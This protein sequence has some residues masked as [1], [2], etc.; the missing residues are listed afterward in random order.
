MEDLDD[1]L[2]DYMLGF[3]PPEDACKL[4]ILS[5]TLRNL[6][7]R[8]LRWKTWCEQDSPSLTTPLAKELV[9]AHYG[10]GHPCGYKRLFQRLSI[11]RC[12]RLKPSCECQMI[13]GE[14]L[15]DF[16]MMVDVY[17]DDEGI[18]FCSAES[19]E[20]GQELRGCI[21]PN[22][23]DFK[24]ACGAVLKV[25]HKFVRRGLS[26]LDWKF[27]CFV[28]RDNVSRV[29]LKNVLRRWL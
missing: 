19:S 17:L 18:L 14:A 27:S 26:D 21:D 4:A 9:E 11:K 10:A 25:A 28:G 2:F 22:C 1:A 3:I 12:A 6:V 8:S 7:D 5:T 16:V 15:F 29:L 20:L 13:N 23:Q 24:Q